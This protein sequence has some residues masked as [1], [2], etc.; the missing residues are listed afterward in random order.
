MNLDLVA[1]QEVGTVG[2][3]EL[4]LIPLGTLKLNVR[5]QSLFFAD[6]LASMFSVETEC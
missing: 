6:F 4:R 3:R 2:R 1:L 5:C